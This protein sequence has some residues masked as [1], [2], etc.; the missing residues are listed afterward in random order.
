MKVLHINT[1]TK[2][3]AA[4]AAIRLHKGLICQGIDSHFL[5]LTPSHFFIPNHHVYKGKVKS[6]K[7]NYPTL[8]FKNWI[9]EK[10]FHKYERENSEYKIKIKER[11]KIV[12]PKIIEGIQNFGLYSLP[13]SRYDI[14]DTKIYKEADII[15]LHWVAGFLDY[16]S[17]FKKNKK[18]IV[19]TL[20]DAN[21]YLGGF[22]HKD[23]FERNYSQYSKLEQE[24]IQFKKKC[25]SHINKMTIVSPSFWLAEDARNSK[26]F[27]DKNV[28]TIRNGLDLSV[29]QKRDKGFSRKL[30][31]L[32]LNKRIFLLASS[33][34]NDYRK[35]IDL[36]LPIIKSEEFQED[37]FLLVGNNFKNEDFKNVVALGG[38][39]DELLMSI[40]YSAVDAFILPS[41]LDNLPNTMLESIACGTP[42]IA[43]DIGDNKNFINDQG[44]ITNQKDLAKVLKNYNIFT[45]ESRDD[46][47][48]NFISREYIKKYINI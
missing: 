35:G 28:L 34:L 7:P 29:F 36:L 48:I 17:F 41:R 42:V 30:L 39:H 14:T 43:F 10:V 31:N 47:D 32:P 1:A 24:L 11:E 15:H 4:I 46:F 6:E 23:D 9:K 2:G 22:H 37:V 38:V 20:H 33:D 18:P 16:E 21:P 8:S 19:W 40:V 13:D 44:V 5:S 26:V 25:Y 27:G 3:G 45:F 12:T